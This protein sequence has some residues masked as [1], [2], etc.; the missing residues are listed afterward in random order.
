MNHG[1]LFTGFGG[2]D[3]ASEWMGW[4]NVFHCEKSKFCQFLLK[5]YWPNAKS[6][7]DICT[8]DF[9]VWRGLI[10]I[11]SGGFPC[12]PYSEAGLRKGTEDARHLW[13]QMLRAIR[14]CRPTW[15]LGENV[16]G[17]IS[18]N[19]GLVFE[20]VQA[21]LENEGYEVQ[22]FVLPAAGV[23]SVH[24]RDR[25]WFVAHSIDARI[26]NE[27][28]WAVTTHQ[29]GSTSYARSNG[30]QSRRPGEDRSTKEKGQGKRDQWE[31][32]WSDDRGIGKPG[33]LT[34]PVSIGLWREI[35]GIREPGFL[36]KEGKEWLFSSNANEQRLEGSEKRGQQQD[37]PPVERHSPQ[38]DADSNGDGLQS[39]RR[40]RRGRAGSKNQ[41]GRITSNT[42]GVNEDLSGLHSGEVRKHG[43][44]ATQVFGDTGSNANS[45]GQQ[46]FNAS[47]IA[48]GQR[49][50]SRIPVTDW[51]HWPTVAPVCGRD[52]GFSDLV[53]S[54]TFHRVFGDGVRKPIIKFPKWRNE[55]IKGYGNAVVPE[56]PFQIFKVIDQM[57]E[58]WRYYSTH[59]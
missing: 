57:N 1:S 4:N 27:R 53:D 31:R 38:V 5:H 43:S 35:N 17:I 10:D 54:E 41:G 23:G 16:I 59:Q 15:V 37:H 7:E 47:A 39:P 14:E 2:F 19:K 3:I 28:G 33:L 29:D 11:I 42:N 20:Q 45:T 55:T 51:I 21:D 40:S 56:V 8:T 13:P 25:V 30:Q 46:E 12:Q 36:G 52:D 22:S 6:Y 49:Y 26:E 24:R 48:D 34:D 9:T 18:W 50:D 44:K 58:I 32:F